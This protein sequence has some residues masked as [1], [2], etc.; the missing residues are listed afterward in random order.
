VRLDLTAAILAAA[1]LAFVSPG[2]AAPRDRAE[3]RMVAVIE[4]EH[5]RN[6]KLLESLVR[7]NSGTMNLAGVEQVG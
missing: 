5:E 6:V 4:A 3:A 1:T 2:Q 7:V